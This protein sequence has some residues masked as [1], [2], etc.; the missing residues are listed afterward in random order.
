MPNI[1]QLEKKPTR[2]PLLSARRE[3]ILYREDIKTSFG[4]AIAGITISL[5]IAGGVYVIEIQKQHESPKSKHL[6]ILRGLMTILYCLRN[7]PSLLQVKDGVIT[8][9]LRI[10]IQKFI[11]YPLTDKNERLSDP[12]TPD[13]DTITKFRQRAAKT[14]ELNHHDAPPNDPEQSESTSH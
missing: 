3:E 10:G 14:A 12:S 8:Y 5:A 9:Y 11:S 4:Y 2:S 13:L 6:K 1:D 7:N